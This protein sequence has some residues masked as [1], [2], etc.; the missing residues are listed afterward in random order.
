VTIVDGIDAMAAHPPV[1]IRIYQSPQSTK[2]TS[3]VSK[4]DEEN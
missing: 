4:K 2:R 3:A 1:Q